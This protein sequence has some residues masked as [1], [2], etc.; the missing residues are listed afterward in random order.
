MPGLMP[1]KSTRM[2]EPTRSFSGCMIGRGII[3]LPV[4][5]A[6][7]TTAPVAFPTL[8]RF[9]I[10][11]VLGRGGMGEVYLADD[12][13]LGRS[14]AVKVLAPEVADDPDRRAFFEREA[15]SAA[16]LNHPNI[17][18]IFEV[19][20]ADGR[21]YIAM[22]AIE[23]RTLS[24]VLRAGPMTESALVEVALQIAS[25]LEEARERNVVHRDLKSGNIMVTA[26]GTAKVLDF[27]LAKQ[28][29]PDR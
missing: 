14:V 21:P 4:D 16:A 20:E 5:Q 1:T 25:A 9:R 8:G 23:G 22:E 12:P 17:C 7:D 18:T 27:G 24:A 3:A 28:V 6:N 13:A 29:E 19:G 26:K 2:P 11:R 15:R 10:V